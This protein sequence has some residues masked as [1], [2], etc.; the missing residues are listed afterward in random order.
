MHS[1]SRNTFTFL[2]RFL[3][4]SGLTMPKVSEKNFR[5]LLKNDGYAYA[6]TLISKGSEPTDI[7]FPNLPDWH[8]EELEVLPDE[9]LPDANAIRFENKGS[10]YKILSNIGDADCNDGCFGALFDS[11][12]DR[13]LDLLS[14]G[15]NET[16]FQSLNADDAKIS[17]DLQAKLSPYLRYNVL[18]NN[19]ELEYLVF[20][21]LAENGC[22]LGLSYF[23]DC[24]EDDDDDEKEG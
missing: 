8:K 22:L 24:S 2:G 1:R 9:A 11:N 12:N 20:K 5:E 17:A 16:T 10:N 15:D 13:V 21:V 23:D 4:V 6:Y 19:T 7:N 3:P 14:T 18:H